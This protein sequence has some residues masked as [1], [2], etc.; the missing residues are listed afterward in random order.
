MRKHSVLMHSL[1]AL[2]VLVAPSAI[3]AEPSAVTSA[4]PAAVAAAN[5]EVGK[6][7]PAF[8]LNDWDGK[9]RKLSDFKGKIVVLEWF[10]HGCPFVKKHYDSKNMQ[11][12]QKKY[13]G[14]KVVWLSICSSAEGKQGCDTG[15]GHKKTFTEKGAAPTAV[16][17]D[18]DGTVGHLYGAK[19]TPHM[20]VIDGKGILVYAGAIDDNN[21]ADP[22][23]T[24][25]AKNYVAAA[26][27]E[28]LA[29]KPVSTNS[30]KAYGCSVK[31]K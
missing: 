21:S 30:T 10:N 13:T 17:L 14:K 7:A 20:F 23:A 24:K 18:T 16:L 2:F 6:T 25:T 11:N 8:T 26:I 22:E 12:L 9:P 19:A 27:D 4:A 15:A 5:A 1:A 29:K 31:Y 3:A 28:T